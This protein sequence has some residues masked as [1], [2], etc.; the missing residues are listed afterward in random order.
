MARDGKD[1]DGELCG[2]LV[3]AVQW[4][5]AEGSDP[6]VDRVYVGSEENG[7]RRLIFYVAYFFNGTGQIP[8]LEL[9]VCWWRQ[10]DGWSIVRAAKDVLRWS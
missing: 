6:R 4:I 7:W 1:F 5:G 2:R 9:L 10:V 8:R 3:S